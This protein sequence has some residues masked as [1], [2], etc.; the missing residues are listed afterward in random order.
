MPDICGQRCDRILSRSKSSL[1]QGSH[2]TVPAGTDVRFDNLRPADLK[3]SLQIK[4]RQ[5]PITAGVHRHIP[6]DSK[7]VP[8]SAQRGKRIVIAV[9]TTG[10]QCT[11]KPRRAA[12]D[13]QAVCPQLFIAFKA[14]PIPAAFHDFV[15][16]SNELPP[17]E[18]L[19]RAA[20]RQSLYCRMLRALSQ[21][22]LP[23]ADL[24]PHDPDIAGRSR[25]GRY[26]CQDSPQR[27]NLF[28]FRTGNKQQA[29]RQRIARNQQAVPAPLDM[30]HQALMHRRIDRGALDVQKRRQIQPIEKIT[31]IT[32]LAAHLGGLA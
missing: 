10:H 12:T 7:Q 9:S 20:L 26:L 3:L 16:K 18:P 31:L 25:Y 22:L 8:G 14:Q 30:I 24:G 21:G 1:D 2:Q 28:P 11:F 4:R 23:P 27:Q 29:G 15:Q 13:S 5:P 32:E 6:N 17:F 19:S